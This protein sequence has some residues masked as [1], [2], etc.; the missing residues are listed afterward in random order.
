MY[1]EFK[2]LV[3]GKEAFPE[4][5]SL[6]RKA[7]QTIEI[8]MF[9][10]RDDEIGNIM[11]KEL[12]SKANEGVKVKISVDRFAS[13]LEKAEEYKL[14]FFHRDQTFIESIK[15]K[16]LRWYMKNLSVKEK[17]TSNSLSLYKEFINHPNI[18]VDKERVKKD[19]SKYYLFD[20]KVLV[21]GGINIEDKELTNDLSGRV[22]QDYM[23]KI[24]SIDVVKTL[25]EKLTSNQNINND[26]YFGINYKENK[27]PI[28]ELKKLYLKLINEANHKL[29]IIMPYFSDIRKI[30]KAIIKKTNEGVNVTIMVPINPNFQKDTN[31]LCIKKLMKKTKNKINLFLSPKMV[32]TKMLM[33][34]K[35]ITI[36]STNIADNSFKVLSELN[37]FIKNTESA[38]HTKLFKSIEENMNLSKKVTSYKSLKYNKIKAF[39]EHFF[40]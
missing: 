29:L 32:H 1:Q 19:H 30:T 22:Y 17:T 8:N 39:L 4:I 26:Y 5:I 23:L 21:M 9:I 31:Y 7:K 33:N 38:F 13:I 15:I 34:E 24:D 14:S 35:E 28:F 2:L 11:I 10:W 27:K 37:I 20:N 12:L 6:I 16:L 40:Q 25:K 36:G 3:D 18:I